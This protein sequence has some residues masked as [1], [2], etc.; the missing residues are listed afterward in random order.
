MKNLIAVITADMVNSTRF[1]SEET[2]KWLHLLLE[3]I[4]SERQE[5][6]LLKPEIYR[7]DSFQG[8]LENPEDALKMA[9]LARVL[10]RSNAPGADLRVAIGIGTT[11]LITDRPGT[12]D[13]EAFRLSGRLSDQ[14]RE[15]HARI[16]FALPT[17][18][19]FLDAAMD[20]LETL[21]DRWTVPQCEVIHRLLMQES[22]T[23]IAGKLAISQSAVSQRVASAKWWAIESLLNSYPKQLQLYAAP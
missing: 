4:R 13:G 9:M 6:W 14:M 7:G 18:V 11:N 22:I 17:P 19:P 12:S 2:G 23:Q 10:M 16:A 8:I 1:S 15:R 21:M 3:E 20:L 5:K